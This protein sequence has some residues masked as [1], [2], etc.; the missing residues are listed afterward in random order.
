MKHRSAMRLWAT[1]FKDIDAE[2]MRAGF[3]VTPRLARDP[4][5]LLVEDLERLAMATAH[6]PRA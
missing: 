4:E 5:S 1:W 2:P 6:L 3:D